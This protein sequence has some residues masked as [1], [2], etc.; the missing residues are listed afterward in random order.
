LAFAGPRPVAGD[1]LLATA[2]GGRLLHHSAV[3]NAKGVE[4]SAQWEA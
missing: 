1:T 3:L 4:L 2:T